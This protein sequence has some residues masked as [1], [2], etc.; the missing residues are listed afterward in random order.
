[1]A[2]VALTLEGCG[3]E[4]V[5]DILDRAPM[6]LLERS[7]LRHREGR[8]AKIIGNSSFFFLTIPRHR[9]EIGD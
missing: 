4:D 1:M 5:D 3:P 2:A 6:V 7:F 8:Y 9:Y